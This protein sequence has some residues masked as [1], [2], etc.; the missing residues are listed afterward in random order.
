MNSYLV[1]AMV[2]YTIALTIYDVLNWTGSM[3]TMNGIF[4]VVKYC[5]YI[6]PP[7]FIGTVFLIYGLNTSYSIMGNIWELVLITTTINVG[8]K[9]TVAY[10]LS[11]SIPA[12]GE[13]LGLVLLIVSI[14]VSKLW[15]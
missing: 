15:K 6:I 5:I 8:V 13:V 12:K 14:F 11:Q 9:L 7:Q 3:V 1:L 10:V 4:D 2:C